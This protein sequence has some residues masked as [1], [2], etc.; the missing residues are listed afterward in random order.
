MT[1]LNEFELQSKTIDWLRF[2]LSVAVVYIHMCPIVDMKT[3]DY[4]SIT[5]NDIYS[6][7]ATLISE[8][9]ARIAVPCFFMF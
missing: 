9:L 6:I 7:I 8:T 1:K 5:G 2:P 3:I 4:L